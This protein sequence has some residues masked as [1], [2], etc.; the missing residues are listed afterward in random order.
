MQLPEPP[1]PL[2]CD[3]RDSPITTDMLID[4]AVAIFGLSV[5]EAESK[6][7]AAISDNPVNLSEVGHG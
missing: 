7:H 4:M 3:V 1:V 6:V 5:E 2:E